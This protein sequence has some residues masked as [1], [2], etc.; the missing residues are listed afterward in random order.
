MSESARSDT[1]QLFFSGDSERW[2]RRSS[3]LPRLPAQPGQGLL[4]SLPQHSP[5]RNSL[6]GRILEASLAGSLI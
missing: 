3:R 2:R 5:A 4:R 1:R 6:P